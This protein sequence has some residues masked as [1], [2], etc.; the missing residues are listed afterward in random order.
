MASPSESNTS[1]HV[2]SQ[3]NKRMHECKKRLGTG[4]QDN[5]CG[6]PY[7][8]PTVPTPPGKPRNGWFPEKLNNTMNQFLVSGKAVI[9]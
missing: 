1:D 5:L 2:R 7:S 4:A 3:N 9:Q 8:L 6:G